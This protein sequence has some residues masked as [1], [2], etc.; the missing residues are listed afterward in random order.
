MPV[1]YIYINLLSF[2]SHFRAYKGLCHVRRTVH[3][4]TVNYWITV[5]KYDKNNA[6]KANHMKSAAGLMCAV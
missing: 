4:I 5:S 3:P 2:I 1:Y 6:M